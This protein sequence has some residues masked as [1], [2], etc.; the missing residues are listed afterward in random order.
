[1]ARLTLSPN[2]LKSPLDL[3][4]AAEPRVAVVE[5]VVEAPAPAVAEAPGPAPSAAAPT[6]TTEA[7]TVTPQP[8]AAPTTPFAVIPDLDAAPPVGD[9]AA[10]SPVAKPVSAPVAG[11]PA[12]AEI[13]G[14]LPA[15]ATTL[16]AAALQPERL[17]G[18][19]K[20]TALI[21]DREL[22]S[23]ADELVAATGP[24]V[25]F[26]ALVIAVLHFYLP[27]DGTAAAKAIG[28]YRRRKLE[29]LDHPWEERNARLPEPLRAEL[30][31]VV[32][33][34]VGRVA[35][36]R[37]ST[38]VNALLDAH[39]PTTADDAARLV[40]RMEMVRGGAFLA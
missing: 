7:P 18:R 28:G 16:D 32:S 23:R 15:W 30:D 24:R 33:G 34:A 19:P 5:P 13:T 21:L 14:D 26:A 38:L 2:G 6:A 39:L 37:R 17:L 3:P 40:T 12:S 20:Q 8:A 36:V 4:T 22:S 27:A 25:T 11:S 10:A 9:D 35:A 1:M 31:D 29:S